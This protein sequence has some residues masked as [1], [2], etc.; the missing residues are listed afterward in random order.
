MRQATQLASDWRRPRL[1]H[2]ARQ[3]PA[4]LLL[5]PGRATAGPSARLG[6][7]HQQAP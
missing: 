6:H 3:S 4:Q 2:A 7:G 1:S 5:G